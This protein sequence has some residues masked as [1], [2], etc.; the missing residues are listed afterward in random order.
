MKENVSGCFFLNT[1]YKESPLVFL[2]YY[3]NIVIFSYCRIVVGIFSG[4]SLQ[5]M[6]RTINTFDILVLF[7][8]SS[9]IFS[10]LFRGFLS[11]QLSS[12]H[13]KQIVF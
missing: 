3:H 13:V 8:R 9:S 11:S 5:K 1:V 7:F 4:D 10:M 6:C 12:L 2:L